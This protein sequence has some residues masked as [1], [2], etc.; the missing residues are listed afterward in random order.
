MSNPL[1]DVEKFLEETP[2]FDLLDPE[3]RH[4]AAAAIEAVYRRTG[5]VL[6]E[7]GDHNETLYI[8]RRGAVEAH[9]RHG[10]FVD[11]YGEGESFGLQS[12]LTGKPV[13]F[14]ITMIE[15]GLVWMMPRAAFD[16]LRARSS[17]F[18]THYLRSLEE[19]LI[20][21]LQ[22][23]NSSGQTLFMTPIG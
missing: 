8:I 4:R 6:L 16:E 1:A 18:G 14:R 2:P 22:P 21:A 20:S 11:R 3:L 23:R 10:N 13:R 15:D 7:V 19:R 17:E 9:D 12:L 5:S